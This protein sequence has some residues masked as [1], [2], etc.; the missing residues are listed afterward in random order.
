MYMNEEQFKPQPNRYLNKNYTGVSSDTVD[1]LKSDKEKEKGKVQ[2]YTPD[3]SK[4]SAQ[5]ANNINK[6]FKS[7]EVV[8]A[9]KVINLK[10][11]L[12][13]L[14]KNQN[15]E[16]REEANRVRKEIATL[17]NPETIS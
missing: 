9:E 10:L 16:N 17:E 14:F 8:V 4:K 6:I 15:K 2:A 7:S 5:L 13:E 1:A 3:K 12:A 11:K